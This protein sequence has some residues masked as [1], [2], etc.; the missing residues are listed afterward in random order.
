MYMGHLWELEKYKEL[1]R[2]LNQLLK[3][4][5]KNMK[6]FPGEMINAD[7]KHGGLGLRSLSEEA[8]ER[9]LK[10]IS[11]G[12]HGEGMTAFAY[13]GM[14]G[15]A[16]RAAGKGGFE[17]TEMRIEKSL[18]QALW[19]SSLIECLDDMRLHLRTCGGDD[20]PKLAVARRDDI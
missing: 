13:S 2:T 4:V 12:V 15:R 19:L 14:M 16:H 5:T 8:N 17:D 1:D 10:M 11:E 3:K 9:K 20:E 6:N 7:Q 18:G